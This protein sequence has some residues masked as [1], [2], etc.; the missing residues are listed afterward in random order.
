MT[1]NKYDELDED[2]KLPKECF[3]SE[4]KEVFEYYY[5][6]NTLFLCKRYNIQE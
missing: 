2:E 4:P 6:R 5:Y 1:D 3:M